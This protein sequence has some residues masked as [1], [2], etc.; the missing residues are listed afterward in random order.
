[1][2]ITFIAS[3]YDYWATA[4]ECAATLKKAGASKVKVVTVTAY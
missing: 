3:S 2:I 1:M 4:N